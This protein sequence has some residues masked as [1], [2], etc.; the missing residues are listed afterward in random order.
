MKNTIKETLNILKC[1]KENIYSEDLEFYKE[2]ENFEDIKPHELK[3]NFQG[4][5]ALVEEL[6]RE[7]VLGSALDAGIELPYPCQTGN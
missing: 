1:P 6:K 3:I 2:P 4:N 5:H 7:N